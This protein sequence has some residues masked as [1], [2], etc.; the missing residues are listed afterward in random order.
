[1]DRKLLPL[2]PDA[3]DA[4]GGL[5]RTKLYDLIGTGELETV[6]VGRRRFG[7]SD[8]IEDYIARLEGTK[9]RPPRTRSQMPRTALPRAT[10]QRLHALIKELDA[11]GHRN[12]ADRVFLALGGR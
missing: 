11:E 12:I 10:E 2:I 3:A 4:L 8:A 7:P 9:A 1:M 5:R 6:K